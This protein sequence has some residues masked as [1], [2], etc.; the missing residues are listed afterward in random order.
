[1]IELIWQPGMTLEDVEKRVILRAFSYFKENKT[2][3]A[4]SL[5]ISVRT[6]DSKLAKYNP[7]KEENA[8]SGTAS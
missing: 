3:T 7:P 1:M 2:Q 4:R 5:N 8:S 6:L